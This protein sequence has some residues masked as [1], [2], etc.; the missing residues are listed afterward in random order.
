MDLATAIIGIASGAASLVAITGQ[1][2]TYLTSIADSYRSAR[3]IVLDLVSTCQA[4][5]AAWSHIR[6]WALEAHAAEV[7]NSESILGQLGTF[8]EVGKVIMDLI[9]GDLDRLS[10]KSSGGGW[11]RTGAKP[12]GI[13]LAQLVLHE[14]IVLD[15]ADRLHRQN[16]S[17][18]LLLSV[19]TLYALQLVT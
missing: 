13:G 9:T 8:L 16:T 3:L 18:N 2:V 7:P 1:V 12:T 17:L 4:Y 14:K 19:L 6:Q 5:E 10:S 15:H 11:W